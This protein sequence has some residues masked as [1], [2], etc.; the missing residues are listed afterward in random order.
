MHG[1]SVPAQ[2]PGR[3]T[4]AEQSTPLPSVSQS[5]YAAAPCVHGEIRT[6]G[7][8][9]HGKLVEWECFIY[10]SP[11]RALNTLMHCYLVRLALQ[12][13]GPLAR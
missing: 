8:W 4:D 13:S 10:F 5:R 9:S 1:M 7:P 2:H 6:H 11:S 3:Q 12:D